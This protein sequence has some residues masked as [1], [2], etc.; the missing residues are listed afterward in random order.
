MNGDMYLVVALTAEGTVNELT[1]YEGD[2]S[3]QGKPM[4]VGPGGIRQFGGDLVRFAD[5][6]RAR[7]GQDGVWTNDPAN[8]GQLPADAERSLG[9][10][11]TGRGGM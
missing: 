2:L 1:L 9:S 7:G 5:Q 10:F 8:H 4:M 11:L 3:W 6:L